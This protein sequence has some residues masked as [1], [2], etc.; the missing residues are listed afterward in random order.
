MI[1]GSFVEGATCR[2]LPL[3]SGKLIAVNFGLLCKKFMQKL[4]LLKVS[5]VKTLES[6]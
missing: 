4:N 5:E 3:E 2:P 6:S 1:S